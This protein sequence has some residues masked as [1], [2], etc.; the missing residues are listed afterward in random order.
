VSIDRKAGWIL[1]LEQ[2]RVLRDPAVEGA[3][4]VRL[5]ADPDPGVRRR[6]VVAI[7]RVGMAEGAT[8]AITALSDPDEQVRAAAAF[9][10]GLIGDAS[11]VAALEAALK[12]PAPLVRGRAAQALGLASAQKS[13]DTIADAFTGCPALISSIPSDDEALQPPEV[14]ACRLAIGALTRLR[15]FS[16]TARLLLDA[17]GQPVS[18]W[19]PLAIAL[20]RSGDDRAAAALV[21]LAS[22]PGVY[23]SSA[24]LRGLTS[25]KDARVV[26][27]ALS[28]ASRN[29]VDVRVRVEAIRALG[30]MGGARAVPALMALLADRSL[31]ANL[32]IEAIRAL[33]SI[34]DRRAF[35]LMLDYFAA[36]APALRAAAMA[37]AA[38]MDPEGLL[39]AVSSS[40]RDRDWTVR[41]NLASVLG[42][43]PRELVLP[44]V[45]ELVKD[46]DV[47]V[48]AAALRALAALGP[49]EADRRILEALQTPDYA[50]RAAAAALV[51]ERRP[52]GGAAALVKAYERG[53]SDATYVARLAALR[54]LAN[55]PIERGRDV[56][57]AALDDREWP[58]RLA[59]ASLLQRLG[60]P[61]ARP[62][63]PALIRQEPLA[64]ESDRVLRPKYTPHAYIETRAGTIQVAL[65][66][67][68]APLTSLT[69]IELA[70][71]GFFD[72]LRVHRL[73]PNFVIQAGDPRGDGGGG[74]GFAIRDE[75]SPAPFLR[76]SM[77][78]ALDGP[79]TAGS[80]FFITLSPQ[81]HL[82]GRYTVFGAVI[83]G[84]DVLDRVSMW[85]VILR[86]RVLDGTPG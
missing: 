4:L 12:D 86:V 43:L 58:I 62:V 82:D 83:G 7:G 40:E 80:Q 53:Q 17:K 28:V 19:W 30:A 65:D 48:Q 26:T 14:E 42:T 63:R 68:E 79:D 72:G 84:W 61:A 73:I 78:M 24:G 47:R 13:A 27:I 41:A 38:R 52:D 77:G 3:D 59:A 10:L 29:D 37:S 25:L 9:T 23:A 1:R 16:A 81:P 76:G 67:I 5:A 75:L 34:G 49:P 85:D 20:Q 31:A 11:G 56:L 54:A 55:Y 50:V 32:A 70:R 6:A 51:G 66:M 35:D 69:F 8:V 2:Q 33:G 15:Q 46:Q 74:P 71:S 45:E 39:F 57:A 21:T 36:P 60:D 18:Q 22:S 44:A 64:F